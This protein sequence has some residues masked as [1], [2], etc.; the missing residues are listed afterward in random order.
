MAFTQDQYDQLQAAIAQGVLKVE[1]ADKKVTYQSRD[2]MI[3]TLRM[4][5]LEL[6]IIAPDNGRRLAQFNKGI[7]PGCDDDIKWIR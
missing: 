6:G 7:R 2:D 5:G 4:I 3:R 1:Y